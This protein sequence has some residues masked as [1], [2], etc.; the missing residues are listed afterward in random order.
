MPHASSG[1][2]LRNRRPP[3]TQPGRRESGW[4]CRSLICADTCDFRPADKGFGDLKPATQSPPINQLQS[5]CDPEENLVLVIVAYGRCCPL[6][7]DG[8][9][10]F[11]FGGRFGLRR[12]LVFNSFIPKPSLSNKLDISLRN[13]IPMPGYSTIICLR[14]GKA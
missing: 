2:S 8:S 4:G 6:E 14:R 3:Y 1:D 5:P 7:N 11:V 9:S 12:L 10:P 13:E